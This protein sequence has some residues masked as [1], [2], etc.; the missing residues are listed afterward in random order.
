MVT[1]SFYPSIWCRSCQFHIH[2]SLRLRWANDHGCTPKR[3]LGSAAVPLDHGPRFQ[4]KD[5]KG[6]F[7]PRRL[8]RSRQNLRSPPPLITSKCG[9]QRFPLDSFLHPRDTINLMSILPTPHT[10]QLE[11]AVGKWPWLYAKALAW[12]CCSSSRS[13][14]SIPAQG[15]KRVFWSET[16]IAIQTKSAISSTIDYIKMWL[17]TL[18]SRQLSTPPGHDQSNVDLANSTHIAAW[19]CGGQMTMAVRQSAGLDLLQFL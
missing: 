5:S 7:D 10:S 19:G 9:Y 8:L 16:S 17:S 6:C 14:S 4:H 2:R 3:W 13:W 18:S 11:A 12:I 15:L 1:S